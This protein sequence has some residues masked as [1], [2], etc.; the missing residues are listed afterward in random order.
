[1]SPIRWTRHP[2]TST[3]IVRPAGMPSSPHALLS[4]TVR[5]DRAEPEWSA[6]VRLANLSG[7]DLVTIPLHLSGHIGT[8]YPTRADAEAAAEA[9]L[10]GW[11][12]AMTE[13]I[14]GGDR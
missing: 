10:R 14:G 11:L 13:R 1:M 12:L 5:A 2:G 4:A 9:A 8:G 7:P 3:A 6:S